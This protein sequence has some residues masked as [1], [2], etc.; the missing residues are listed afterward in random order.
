MKGSRWEF[1]VL[2][3]SC[4]EHYVSILLLQHRGVVRPASVIIFLIEL[5]DPP[6]ELRAPPRGSQTWRNLWGGGFGGAAVLGTVSHRGDSRGDSG[7]L[8]SRR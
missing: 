1:L 6:G 4:K 7:T 2:L 5:R 8:S 3:G